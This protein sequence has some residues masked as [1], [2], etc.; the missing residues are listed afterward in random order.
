MLNDKVTVVAGLTR[1]MD[2]TCTLESARGFRLRLARS[3][4]AAA[5]A[6][7]LPLYAAAQVRQGAVPE[8]EV[9]DTVRDF[10]LPADKLAVALEAFSTQS[11][12]RLDSQPGLLADR[13]ARAVSGRMDWRE[14]LGQLL[15]SSGLEYRQT[16]DTTAV[17]ATAGEG[18]A[19]ADGPTRA[20]PETTTPR[21]AATDLE[22]VTVTGTRIRGGTSP[23]PVV[24]IGSERIREEGFAD[25]GQVIR[26]VPQNFSG[27]QNP[28][29][30]SG[31]V[32]GGSA[33]QN[34]TGGS[35]VNLRGLG[36]DATLT[37]LNGKRLSYDGIGQAVDISV[38]PVG[39]VERVEIVPD[40]ASALYG[41]DAV[42]G[43]VNVILKRDFD[44]V[45][46]GTRYAGSTNGGLATREVFTTA[47]TTWDSGGVMAT[48]SR[49][50][51]D[52]IFVDQR[53]YTDS[54]GDPTTLYPGIDTSNGLVSLHQSLGGAVQL[55]VDALRTKREQTQ[56]IDYGTFYYYAIPT[57]TMTALAPSLTFALARDWT[58]TASAAY[59]KNE[60]V[61]RT[62]EV[63]GEADVLRSLGCY[64]NE[65]RSFEFGAEGPLFALRGGDARMAI[66]MGSRA[67]E[68]W[69][70]SYLVGNRS[71]SK[72]RARYGYA[73]L[74]LPFI[75]S[76]L[77]VAGVNRLM[78][79]AA[80]RAEDHDSFGQVSTPKLGLIY[81]PFPAAS[82]KLSW[83]ESFKAPTL[84][85][86]SPESRVA[87]YTAATAGGIGYSPDASV[88]VASGSNPSLKPERART[89][90]ASLAFHPES[91]PGL[92]GELTWFDVEYDDRVMQPVAAVR[93]ALSNPNFAEFVQYGP[94]TEEQLAFVAG[95]PEFRNFT[96]AE[97]DPATV[98]A[99]V[100]NQFVNVARQ[101][102]RGVDL[103]GAYR[104]D[105]DAG[106]LA[107]R[108][109]V[110]RL[111]S[112]QQ[113]NRGQ[114]FYDLAG[115]IFNPA[116]YRGRVGA[117]WTQGGFSA[118]GFTNF[119]SGVT[120]QLIAGR[121]EKTAS[122][123]TVDTT[124]RYDIG[125]RG[126]AWSGLA[127]ELSVQNLF[128]RAPPLYT[129]VSAMHPPFDSTN[130]SAI[131]RYVG[132]S[133]T[134]SW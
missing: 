70:E 53:D 65:S 94:T 75:S 25:M 116:K 123:V 85:Q 41:S 3:A 15:Q 9:A 117:V 66:G 76:E 113:N 96:A 42:G 84:Y 67:S 13:Q 95:F 100:R 98:I 1:S 74:S 78:V 134:K 48:W 111:D 56:Y 88:L 72:G 27:G 87:L 21:A 101:R 131:G 20:R 7:M 107:V 49:S 26:S 106:R 126:D 36:P 32:A 4:L 82:F 37:L 97:Y 122:F 86:Q 34:F 19:S 22:A 127:F 80:I 44:G 33:N 2:R 52:P 110:S 11:G 79:S 30:A 18:A 39:A 38:I 68:Y 43:V 40:G 59:G 54:V 128:D 28:G 62:Y 31:A 35:A 112:E 115:T 119:A 51:S 93:Q 92:E 105:I 6:S 17:I 90:T 10:D 103:S 63:A 69:S 109:S 120:S 64:C 16:G 121:A 58:L 23:S 99:I 47:G 5:V 77:D 108:G 130:Y 71:P 57:T 50:S 45:T 132:V 125:P 129:T 24:T 29:V 73:E 91:L 133:M 60:Y 46:V 55:Q 114:E 83:G 12:I 81:A 14:A 102:I 124:L 118:S 8:I 61:F 104:F 89:W